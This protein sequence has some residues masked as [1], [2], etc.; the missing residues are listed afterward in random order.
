MN[1]TKIVAAT[2]GPAGERPRSDLKVDY[3]PG[4]DGLGVEISSKVDYLYG[5]AIDA[6]VTRV[7]ES[8]GVTTGRLAINDAGAVEWVILA[9]VEACLR[10]AGFEG[11][12][13]LPEA[14]PG[15][16]GATTRDRL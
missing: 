15:A 7:V 14:A 16:L 6:A 2:A 10:R 5:E 11:P 1:D 13:V 4:A 9:R 3:Q 8:F 12:P